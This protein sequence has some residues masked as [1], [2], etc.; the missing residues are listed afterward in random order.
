MTVTCTCGTRVDAQTRE[1][2]GTVSAQG[3]ACDH[4]AAGGRPE[5]SKN[6]RPAG[7]EAK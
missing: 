7:L 4:R 2:V 5:E 1:P 3:T 6:G